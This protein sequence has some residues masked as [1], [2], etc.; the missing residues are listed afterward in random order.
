MSIHTAVITGS[1]SGLG[2]AFARQLAAQGFSLVLVARDRDRLEGQSEALSS[3]YG[4]RAA[5]IVADLVTDEGVNAVQERLSD[6]AKPVHLLVNNAGHGLAEDFVDSS[7][8]AE[9]GLLRLHVQTTMELSH[10]AARSMSRRHGGRIINVASVAGFTPTGTYSA[11]KAWVINFSKALH[12]QLRGDGVAV[13]ALCPGLVRTEFHPRSGIKIRGAKRWMWLD[14]EDV[15]RQ[16]LAANAQGSAMCIPSRSYQMLTSSLKFVPDSMVQWAVS[17]RSGSSS[18]PQ[19]TLEQGD[20]ASPPAAPSAG[21]TQRS[22]ARADEDKTADPTTDAIRTVDA[23]KASR[24]SLPKPPKNA[25]SAP[26][27][28]GYSSPR[29]GEVEHGADAPETEA[30]DQQEPAS[31]EQSSGP[32]GGRQQIDSVQKQE[33]NPLQK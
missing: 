1:T 28:A 29:T 16:G 13:T 19:R 33:K 9:R 17:R 3:Q 20:A 6:P 30:S 14:P 26:S 32:Q 8:E 24:M 5:F 27:A 31:G 22:P 12:Q 25:S 18:T 2:A 11:A 15:V 21:A 7:L 4:V 23:Y 10:T